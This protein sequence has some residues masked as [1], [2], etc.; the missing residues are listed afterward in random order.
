VVLKERCYISEYQGVYS[1]FLTTDS[2]RCNWMLMNNIAGF[3]YKDLNRAIF[4]EGY[5]FQT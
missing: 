4:T 1:R 2:E 3:G 5:S